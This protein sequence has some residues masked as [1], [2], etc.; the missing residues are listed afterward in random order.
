MAQEP[1]ADLQGKII[2]PGMAP[3]PRSV[4]LVIHTTEIPRGIGLNLTVQVNRHGYG[5]SLGLVQT[6][7]ACTGS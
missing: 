6:S 4:A 2:G 7:P 1:N 5:W 3:D